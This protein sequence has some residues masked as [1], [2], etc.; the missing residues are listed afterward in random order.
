MPKGG[1][2]SIIIIIMSSCVAGLLLKCA[3]IYKDNYITPEKSQG[4]PKPVL[5]RFS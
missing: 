1:L 5:A 3:R 2:Y 4:L